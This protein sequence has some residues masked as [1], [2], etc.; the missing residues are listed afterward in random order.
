MAWGLFPLVFAA[1]NMRLDRIG[2]LAAIYPATWGATQLLTG[3]LSDRLGRKWLIA[4]GMWTQAI[5]IGVVIL[6]RTFVGF[7]AGAVWL[8]FCIG[9]IE[10]AR[11]FLRAAAKL[12]MAARS[13]ANLIPDPTVPSPEIVIS[14]KT[15]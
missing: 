6:S 15:V 9:L 4:G 12:K 8:G 3:A 1:A 5:G 7:A 11:V 14:E 13:L 10:A 2:A